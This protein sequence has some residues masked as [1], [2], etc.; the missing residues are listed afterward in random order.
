MQAIP[1]KAQSVRFD[2]MF[3]PWKDL[4]FFFLPVPLAFLMFSAAQTFKIS[5]AVLYAVILLEVIGLGAFHQGATWFHFLDRENRQH[6]FLGWKG[7]LN[8]VAGPLLLFLATV[9]GE[10]YYPALTFFLYVCWSL[11]HAVQQNIGVLLLYQNSKSDEVKIPRSIQSWS[12]RFMAL[13]FA[14]MF[15]RRVLLPGQTALGDLMWFPIGLSLLV[16]IGYSI[17]YIFT[18]G[19]Q[20]S[21]GKY[22]NMPSFLFWLLCVAYL[23]PFA[24]LGNNYD[25]A[26][27]IP[28]VV[29]W[30]Q[31]IGINYIVAQRKYDGGLS[32]NLPIKHPV[33]LYLISGFALVALAVTLT[34]IQ[35]AESNET[36]PGQLLAG[37]LLGLG[38]VHYYLDGFIWRFRDKFPREAMLPYLIRR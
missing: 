29:H 25:D 19:N 12:Q 35:K 27:M 20:L 9:A 15:F 18:L 11:N 2:W 37:A 22:V 10:V 7:K 13:S 8:F 28:L 3:S 36:L 24:F 26:V 30:C 33:L 16:G 14:L 6:Y 4:L 1:Q 23:I 34:Y 32:D 31:Y 21:A 38:M 5:N 17:A